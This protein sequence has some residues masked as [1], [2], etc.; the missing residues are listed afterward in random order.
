MKRSGC[1]FILSG[2]SGSGK[3]TLRQEILK[4]FPNMVYSVSYTTRK[5]RE[6]EQSGRDYCFITEVAFKTGI[7]SG[8]WIEWAQ[9]YG[10]YYGTS[11]VFLDRELSRGRD[12]L[13]DIDIQ[14]TR[15][16][17]RKFKECIPI[18]IM[19][20]SLDVL[21]ERLEK[22]GSEIGASLERRL[23]DARTEITQIQMYRHVV[24]NDRLEEAVS[25][26][27]DLIQGYRT[28]C[29]NLCL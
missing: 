28:R 18:F 15:Q 26:L 12:V 22:R 5:P 4:R 27:T 13:L 11:A 23:D 7:E 9:V 14:G 29:K 2:P 10:N 21:R 1:L 8:E 3:T 20:P 24:I 16:I 25:E 17:L 19:P 6:K